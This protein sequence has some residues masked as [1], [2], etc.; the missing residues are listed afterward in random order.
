M[1]RVKLIIGTDKEKK[2]LFI[3]EI[4]GLYNE[5]NISFITGEDKLHKFFYSNCNKNTELIIIEGFNDTRRIMDIYCGLLEGIRV[6]KRFES[7][8]YIQ[9]K[10][11]IVVCDSSVSMDDF[12]IKTSIAF[13]RRFEIIECGVDNSTQINKIKKITGSISIKPTGIHGRY[14]FLYSQSKWFDGCEYFTIKDDGECLIIKKCTGIDM[15]KKAY[16]FSKSKKFCLE[17]DLPTGKFEIDKDESNEDILFI[18]Y[19]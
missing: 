15:P 10:G 2:D 8:F 9:P 16:K 19:K 17:S 18:Y 11:I 7:P 5:E 4:V 6:E 14:R 13:N 3:N 12:P 1:E